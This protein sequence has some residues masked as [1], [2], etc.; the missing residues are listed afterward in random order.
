MLSLGA[1]RVGLGCSGKFFRR[2]R[3]QI[4]SQKLCRR[5]IRL[6]IVPIYAFVTNGVKIK[7]G[8]LSGTSSE[9]ELRYASIRFW[10]ISIFNMFNSI[11]HFG[12]YFQT[13]LNML[14]YIFK[15]LLYFPKP[16]RRV[17][18][19]HFVWRAGQLPIFYFD[20]IRDKNVKWARAQMNGPKSCIIMH[21]YA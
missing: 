3:H 17:S 9:A 1:W 20:P 18:K 6:H 7:D 13:C 19:F 5:C 14:D 21:N 10:K 4:G 16:N 8:E 12:L 2:R 11:E 15:Y